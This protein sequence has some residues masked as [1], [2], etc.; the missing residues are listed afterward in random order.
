[1]KDSQKN[2]SSSLDIDYHPG[3]RQPAVLPIKPGLPT[4]QGLYDPRYEHDACGVGFVVNI[5]G[6][7]SHEIVE[8]GLTVL[9]NLDHRG[10]RG[11]EDNTGDGAGILFQLP[12]KFFNKVCPDLG[13]ELPEP[14]QYG[15]GMLFLP[16]DAAGTPAV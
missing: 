14:G 16:K 5:K 2:S 13:I 7:R 9:L 11:A 4:K 6:N 10:A 8:Q 15:V 1:M 3:D 12:H